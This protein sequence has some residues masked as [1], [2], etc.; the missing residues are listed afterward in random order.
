MT[1]Q[2]KPVQAVRLELG[3]HPDPL[4][5]LRSTARVLAE[6][7]AVR[8]DEGAITSLAGRLTHYAPAPQEADRLHPTFLPPRRFLN[9]LLALEALNF[10][11]WDEAPRWRV[12]YG[13]GL[14]DGYWALVAAFHRALREAAWPLW[15]AQFLGTITESVL[16]ALLRGEGRPVPL[17][18]ERTL[19]LREL[20]QGLLER[21]DGQFANLLEQ[22]AGEAATLAGLIASEFPSF[23]DRA[24]WRGESVIFLK[25]AQICVADL[26]RLLP[27]P[28]GGRLHRLEALTAFADYKVPQVLR[29]EGVL[30]LAPELAEAV[31]GGQELPA[32]TEPELA[33]RA[34]TV[35]GCHLLAQAV[36]QEKGLADPVPAME[37]DYLLWV[38]GQDKE[39]LPPYHRTR[40]I[41]Y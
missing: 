36:G 2:T 3:R 40:T 21:W 37:V 20:G 9:T 30:V 12:R 35:W 32:G 31:A 41:Y 38:M 19:H 14:H 7:T 8:L 25:R 13:S 4:G 1:E 27:D 6:T 11:F 22:C 23:Q 16:A 17:L 24:P 10:C 29:K 34:A 33:I 5:V 18:A 15:D 26:S 39:G 28:P